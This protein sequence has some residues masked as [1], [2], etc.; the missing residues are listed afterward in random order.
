MTKAA[1]CS[2]AKL[3]INSLLLIKMCCG[4]DF[5]KKQTGR[6]QW[7]FVYNADQHV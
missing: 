6:Y 3:S 2:Y 7:I 1:A 5:F 4:A